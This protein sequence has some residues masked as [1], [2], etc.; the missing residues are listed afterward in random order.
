MPLETA[1]HVADL[2]PSNPVATDATAQGDDHLRL[3]KTALRNT[4]PNFTSAPLG[5]LKPT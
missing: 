1:S 4:F 5:P 3:I 2:D